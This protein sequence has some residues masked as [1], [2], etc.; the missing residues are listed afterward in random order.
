MYALSLT[1]IRILCM[2]TFQMDAAC[3]YQM[4]RL[5]VI[6]LLVQIDGAAVTFAINMMLLS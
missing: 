6:L 2:H 1:P 3:I 5:G 4:Q